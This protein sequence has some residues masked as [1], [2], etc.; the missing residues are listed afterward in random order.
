MAQL[1]AWAHKQIAD[2]GVSEKNTHRIHDI[3]IGLL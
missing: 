1:F 2:M 3:D